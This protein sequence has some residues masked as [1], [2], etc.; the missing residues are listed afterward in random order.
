[1]RLTTLLAALALSVA[2]P[3]IA[4]TGKTDT[5][6]PYVKA[7]IPAPSRAWTGADYTQAVNVLE[8]GASPLPRFS[9]SNG[10]AVLNRMTAVENLDFYR[11]PSV[12]LETRYGDYLALSIGINTLMTLYLDSPRDSAGKTQL[13]TA[14]IVAYRLRVA[15]AGLDLVDELI[16]TVP[17]DEKYAT[18]VAN[19]KTMQTA[20]SSTLGDAEVMLTAEHGFSAAGR[21]LVLKAMADTLP[22]LKRA[23]QPFYKEELR[24]RLEADRAKLNDAEDRRLLDDMIGQLDNLGLCHGLLRKGLRVPSSE[25]EPPRK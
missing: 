18:R 19:M 5:P 17:K 12:P 21:S 25:L 1:M 24:Q 4:Q 7:G 6:S 13:E 2:Q 8:S 16:S 22:T 11:N 23:F 9:D 15:V 3:A 20:Y 14:A 10:A